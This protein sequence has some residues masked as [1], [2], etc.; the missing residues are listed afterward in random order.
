MVLSRLI[1]FYKFY[2][3]NEYDEHVKKKTKLDKPG[4]KILGITNNKSTTQTPQLGETQ[5]PEKTMAEVMYLSIMVIIAT[6][7]LMS[8]SFIGTW[9]K[10]H[11]H[12]NA[13][14]GHD[15]NIQEKHTGQSH[16]THHKKKEN[17]VPDIVALSLVFV[18]MWMLLTTEFIAIKRR[19][20]YLDEEPENEEQAQLQELARNIWMA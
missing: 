15:H 3:K 5:R 6:L 10:V 11:K 13:S 1:E 16:G 19:A 17:H 4:P 18:G 12:R 7:L 9:N 2:K 20:E 8:A 14:R